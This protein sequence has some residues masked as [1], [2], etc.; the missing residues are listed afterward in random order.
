MEGLKDQMEWLDSLDR[1]L[2]SNTLVKDYF[3]WV[4]VQHRPKPNLISITIYEIGYLL[5]DINWKRG[6]DDLSFF[7]T[8]L[9]QT[10]R[11]YALNEQPLIWSYLGFVWWLLIDGQPFTPQKVD[12]DTCEAYSVDVLNPGSVLGMRYSPID[13]NEKRDLLFAP[14]GNFFLP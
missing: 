11:N 13:D 6:N 1:E 3:K 7:N 14:L 5:Y 9:W 4:E 8:V 10:R 2:S 12:A